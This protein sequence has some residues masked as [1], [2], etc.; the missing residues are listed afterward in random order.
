M[1]NFAMDSCSREIHG[2]PSLGS[3]LVLGCLRAVCVEWITAYLLTGLLKIGSDGKTAPTT[4][5]TTFTIR[6]ILVPAVRK[7]K[8][9]F[10]TLGCQRLMY[11]AVS[12]VPVKILL[13]AFE[14]TMTLF[15]V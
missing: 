9:E 3:W 5:R 4:K 11:Q 14:E 13:R 12:S 1:P 6:T 2:R 15:A 7:L 8:S 10:D